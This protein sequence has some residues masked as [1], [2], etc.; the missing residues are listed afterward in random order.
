[1]A[2]HDRSSRRSA[3]GGSSGPTAQ[4]PRRPSELRARSRSAQATDPASRPHA[5]LAACRRSTSRLRFVRR[6]GPIRRTSSWWC[7]SPT[8]MRPA[9]RPPARTRV[10]RRREPPA[11]CRQ[12]RWPARVSARLPPALE[13]TNSRI[14]APAWL[15]APRDRQSPE[16]TAGRSA[17][18]S[19]RSPKARNS[20]AHMPRSRAIRPR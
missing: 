5:L 17:D 10:A 15:L 13:R 18:R 20:S 6:R 1:M 16:V 9:W 8:R 14:R 12:H 4:P 19:R 3:R 2:G 11:H 7:R